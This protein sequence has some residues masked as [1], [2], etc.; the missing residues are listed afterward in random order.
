MNTPQPPEDIESVI[1]KILNEFDECFSDVFFDADGMHI[2]KNDPKCIPVMNMSDIKRFFSAHLL[3]SYE[4]GV[5]GG[6]ASMKADIE[7]VMP[8]EEDCICDRGE[9]TCA[10][11]GWNDCRSQL[12]DNM[13]KI[14]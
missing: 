1:D 14:V 4:A 5:A 6:R 11:C 10:N 2:I 7:T 9:P 13:K 3:T 8:E 12:L